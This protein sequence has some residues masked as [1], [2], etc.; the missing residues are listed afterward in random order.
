M[1][2]VTSFHQTCGE[3]LLLLRLALL[4]M[5]PNRSLGSHGSCNQC[6]AITGGRKPYDIACHCGRP[7]QHRSAS[8]PVVLSRI[9]S[10]RYSLLPS[11]SIFICAGVSD[12]AVTN[13]ALVLSL[14]LSVFGLMTV[15]VN[16]LSL[17]HHWLSI[18]LLLFVFGLLTVIVN[19][20]SLSSYLRWLS[21]RS[22]TLF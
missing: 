22:L 5:E 21:C 13:N 10:S 17:C 4:L 11:L 19:S 2:R 14:L 6:S 16:S 9:T 12:G 3:W 7:L 20:L 15:I 18:A 8:L 1:Q